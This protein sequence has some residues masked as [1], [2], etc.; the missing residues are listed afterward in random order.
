MKSKNCRDICR[1]S[2]SD[3]QIK[4][5]MYANIVT[6]ISEQQNS[7]TVVSTVNVLKF[8]TKLYNF[9]SCCSKF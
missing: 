2:V 3:F 8:R 7:I 6:C 5:T 1:S 4:D 9:S